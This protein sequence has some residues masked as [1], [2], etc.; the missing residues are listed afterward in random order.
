MSEVGITFTHWELHRTSLSARIYIKCISCS[1]CI[2]STY[3]HRDYLQ[4]NKN[5]FISYQLSIYLSMAYCWD[6]TT[7]H[8]IGHGMIDF[9]NSMIDNNYVETIPEWIDELKNVNIQFIFIDLFHN[10]AFI[11][12]E[13][14]Y[15]D[16]QGYSWCVRPWW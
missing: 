14:V 9:K 2:S 7:D 13:K 5:N 15:T 6:T 8:L 3:T 10:T 11:S 16:G 1:N 12:D 4:P